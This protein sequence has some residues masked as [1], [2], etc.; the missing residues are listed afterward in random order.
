MS[1]IYLSCN[2]CGTGPTA[3]SKIALSALDA[4][5]SFGLLI[6]YATSSEDKPYLFKN[7][8]V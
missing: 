2:A 3:A 1:F 5:G 8:L 6:A 7:V 4:L